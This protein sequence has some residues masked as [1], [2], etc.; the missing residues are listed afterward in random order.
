MAISEPVGVNEVSITWWEPVVCVYS[1]LKNSS[2]ADQL[3]VDTAVISAFYG[4][5]Y[6]YY[7]LAR[8]LVRE[9][10][11]TFENITGDGILATFFDMHDSTATVRALK[12]ALGLIALGQDKIGAA[13]MR[14]SA[15]ENVEIGTRIGIARGTIL[16]GFVDNWRIIKGDVINLA[17][18]LEALADPD[19]V[20]VDAATIVEIER[21]AP[22]LLVGAV[23]EIVEAAKLKGQSADVIAY[24]V[25]GLPIVGVK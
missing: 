4:L 25:S 14:K 2:R 17:A 15:N 10:G 19:A 23:R 11:G 7:R 18:R 13:L 1:D 6:G 8:R 9:H 5:N 24:R 20:L 22:E 21:A 16:V 12:Y 3:V